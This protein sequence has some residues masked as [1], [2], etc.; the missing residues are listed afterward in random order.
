MATTPTASS[1][2]ARLRRAGFNPLGSGTSRTREGLRVA[3]GFVGVTV[4]AD[5]DVERAAAAM[6][7]DAADALADLTIER[8]APAIFRVTA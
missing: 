3:D 1:I 8:I 5:L 7:R 2:S 6:S 4:T